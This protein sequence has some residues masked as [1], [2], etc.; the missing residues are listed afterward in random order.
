MFLFV[1]LMAGPMRR[2][3]DVTRGVLEGGAVSCGIS[4]AI[5]S[6][7]GRDSGG[8]ERP[9]P[10]QPTRMDGALPSPVSRRYNNLP[11]SAY[12]CVCVCDTSPHHVVEVVV[13]VVREEGGDKRASRRRRQ[14]LWH[15]RA[16]PDNWKW[17]HI[18]VKV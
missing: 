11:A 17:T 10:T 18:Q 8:T 12:V 13:V 3:T 4:N 9:H 14:L 6:H 16:T 2:P 5:R 1:R 15:R 7:S